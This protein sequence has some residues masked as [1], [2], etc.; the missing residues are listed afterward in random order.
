M[1]TFWAATRTKRRRPRRKRPQPLWQHPIPFRPPAAKALSS[2]PS[3]H[4][5]KKR[6]NNRQHLSTISQLRPLI[7]PAPPTWIWSI[8][9]RTKTLGRSTRRIRTN[10]E[11]VL[12]PKV[13]RES[14]TRPRRSPSPTIM[15]TWSA[16]SW[17][18]VEPAI[19]VM[20]L[21]GVYRASRDPCP[22]TC[23]ISSR[24]PMEVIVANRGDSFL[25]LKKKI[26]VQVDEIQ[27]F[28]YVSSFFEL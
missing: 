3:F 9:I 7:Q 8:W 27:T 13:K 18:M 2:N 19:R 15:P 12:V 6:P 4:A 28:C 20:W 11:L 14:S 25:I 17:R 21:L 16:N 26:N 24:L 23:W 1:L 5:T 10:S 22:S